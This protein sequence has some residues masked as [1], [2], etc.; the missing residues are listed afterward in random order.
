MAE[1]SFDI[2]A[3]TQDA[4]NHHVFGVDAVDDDVLALRGSCACRD[5]NPRRGRG[6]DTG[7]LPAVWF[8]HER[9]AARCWIG[10]HKPTYWR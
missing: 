6:Q 5:V 4:K 3:A 2:P 10:G 9:D 8:R 1:Q 7:G